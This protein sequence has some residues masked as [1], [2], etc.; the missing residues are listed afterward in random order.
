VSKHSKAGSDVAVDKLLKSW[1]DNVRVADIAELGGLPA[2]QSR[3]LIDQLLDTLPVGPMGA[4]EATRLSQ[5]IAVLNALA[6][7]PDRGK[8]EALESRYNQTQKLPKSVDEQLKQLKRM[9]SRPPA[10]PG[11]LGTDPTPSTYDYSTTI[12][13]GAG[14][15]RATTAPP[16]RP[17]NK[18]D[19]GSG[20]GGTTPPPPA[21]AEDRYFNAEIEDHD[22][23]QP[24]QAGAQYSVAF[25]IDSVR[26][27]LSGD[28]AL[29]L[30]ALFADTDDQIRVLTV[31]IAAQGFE[32]L[33]QAQQS[34]QLPPTGKSRGRARFD[35]SP[36]GTASRC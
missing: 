17:P 14:A 5:L 27:V 1:P 30:H 11:V 19:A 36:R 26:R 13:A 15:P 21:S 24:L 6:V 8:I 2:A 31:Q 34:L 18:T 22:L 4:S 9:A 20:S 23:T 7:K 29:P 33:G 12:T 35:V 32:I 25:D 28:K 3:R 16:T 10:T